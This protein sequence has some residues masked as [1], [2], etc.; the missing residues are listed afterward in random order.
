[1]ETIIEMIS[2]SED[3]LCTGIGLGLF[4]VI[5]IA[6]PL[7]CIEKDKERKILEMEARNT[8]TYYDQGCFHTDLNIFSMFGI[9]ATCTEHR[10]K[11]LSYNPYKLYDIVLQTRDNRIIIAKDCIRRYKTDGWLTSSDGFKIYF[12]WFP[13]DRNYTILTIN[14]KYR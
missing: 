12:D 7:F 13:G 1:M 9:D 11:T 5:L 14:E 10:I 8:I 2:T 4:V 3:P 6:W